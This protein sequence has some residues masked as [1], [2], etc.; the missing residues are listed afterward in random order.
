M[1]LGSLFVYFFFILE[2]QPQGRSVL[3]ILPYCSLCKMANFAKATT[4]VCHFS[5]VKFVFERFFCVG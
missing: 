3:T 4:K 5:N 2:I 1:C